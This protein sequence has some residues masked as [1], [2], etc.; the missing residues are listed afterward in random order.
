MSLIRRDDWVDVKGE[1]EVLAQMSANSLTGGS[2][3]VLKCDRETGAAVDGW[4]VF[5]TH[6]IGGKKY[7]YWNLLKICLN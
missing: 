4:C 2:P 3:W 5:M 6:L 7:I 1:E